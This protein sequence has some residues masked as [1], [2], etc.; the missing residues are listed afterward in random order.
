MGRFKGL[1][2]F[3]FCLFPMLLDAEEIPQARARQ[4]AERF[5]SNMP[6]TKSSSVDL[7]M[8]WDGNDLQTKA[9][10]E[11]PAFYVFDNAAGPGFV[12]VAG[13]DCAKPILGYSFSEDFVLEGMPANIR[14]WMEG[15]KELILQA[16]SHGPAPN[17]A[18]SEV[19]EVMLKYETAKWDQ[20]YPYNLQCPYDQLYRSVTGCLATAIAIVMRYHKWPD[21]G[22]GTI[23]EYV[24]YTKG[25]NVSARDVS[26]AYD[27]DHMPLDYTG[28][29]EG[30]AEADAVAQLMA[31]CGSMV[32]MDYTSV[33]S[34]ASGIYTAGGLSTYMKYDASAGC[35]N[36]GVYTDREWHSMLEKELADN[37]PI[38]YTGQS[39]SGGHAFVLDGYTSENYYSVNWGWSGY[40]NGF[41]TLDVLDPAD[42]GIGGSGYAFNSQQTAILNLKKDEGGIHEVRAIFTEYNGLRGL[43]TEETYFAPGVP[44]TI[45]ASL[46]MNVSSA[47]YTG[48]MGFALADRYD[49]V[50][51]IL[52]TFDVVELPTHYGYYFSSLDLV[53]ESE[54]EDGDRL[55]AVIWDESIPGWKK[56]EGDMELGC[57]DYIV[58]CDKVTIEE[59]TTVSYDTQ[60]RQIVLTV[61]EGVSAGLLDENGNDC[62]TVVSQSGT[63]II[64]DAS[65]L[66]GRYKLILS[67]GSE[68]KELKFVL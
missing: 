31:D 55:I 36:R 30:S 52:G 61:K 58:L 34:G 65:L 1:F 11:A 35:F 16:R 26:A 50:K 6:Q 42:Q 41:F 20:G 3:L 14:E 8:I 47:P 22:V 51:E 33:E 4:T 62:S 15:L 7:Q 10:A 64:I 44:F 60:T 49:Q 12:I 17:V 39:E 28:V 46:M 59:T 18:S 43:A 54:L 19:G 27:W 5:F 45:S 9:Y 57:V 37:G 23:P 66:S 68:S 21:A 40:C 63:D 56:I 32:Q 48:S 29:T 2:I 38:I 25:L 67:D 13:D 53:F 24:T